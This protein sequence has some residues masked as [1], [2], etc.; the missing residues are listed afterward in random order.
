MTYASRKRIGFLNNFSQVADGADCKQIQNGKVSAAD[1]FQT[2]QSHRQAATAAAAAAAVRTSSSFGG[3]C[4][5]V[6][7]HFCVAHS[8]RTHPFVAVWMDS[9]ASQKTDKLDHATP[10]LE[11]A[12]AQSDNQTTHTLLILEKG[13]SFCRRTSHSEIE[14]V[15]KSQYMIFT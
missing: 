2:R 9:E 7:G 3:N 10:Q 4:L 5:S 13:S 12:R 14:S 15:K 11:A 1:N 6:L 8:R